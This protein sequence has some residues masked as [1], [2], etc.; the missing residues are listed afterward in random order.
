MLRFVPLA[1][2]LIAI[3][4]LDIDHVFTCHLDDGTVNSLVL[5]GLHVYGGVLLLFIL[6]WGFVLPDRLPSVFLAACGV[7]LHYVCGRRFLLCDSLSHAITDCFRCVDVDDFAEYS[8]SPT[9]RICSQGLSMVLP[10][11]CNFLLR[12]TTIR[13]LYLKLETSA[14]YR[15]MRFIASTDAACRR[16]FLLVV[17]PTRVTHFSDAGRIAS[18]VAPYISREALY[19]KAGSA[20]PDGKRLLE[21]PQKKR[22]I[23]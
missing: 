19:V 14:Q 2:G 11:R 18:S 12:R 17:Q 7:A 15:A 8:T 20:I 4:A 21:T 9:R 16:C 23:S 6:I 5:H 13:P 22:G 1:S 3:N 10:E